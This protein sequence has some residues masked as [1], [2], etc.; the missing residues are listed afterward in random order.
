MSTEIN[1]NLYPKLAKSLDARLGSVANAASLP[2]IA[3]TSNFLFEGAIIY[4]QDETTNY[5]VQVLL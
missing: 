2:V 1:N 4:V 5:Q 3:N